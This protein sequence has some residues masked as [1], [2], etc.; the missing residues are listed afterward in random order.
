MKSIKFILPVVIISLIYLL[1]KLF[2]PEPTDWNPSYSKNDKIPYGSYILYEELNQLFPGKNIETT[3]LPFYNISKQRKIEDK[4][5]IIICYKF[6][7]D[8]LDAK[9]LLELLNSG[10]D[11][12]I[13]ATSVGNVFSDSLN[14]QTSFS[15]YFNSDSTEVNFVNPALARKTDYFFSNGKY[16]IYFSEIDT[17]NTIVLGINENDNPNFIKMKIGKGNLFLHSIPNIFTNYNLLKSNRDYIFKSLSYLK[18]RDVIWDEYYKE[19]NKY[20][21]TPIRY[22]LSQTSL[23]WGY[24]TFLFGIILFVIFR[25]KRDQRII[26]VIKPLTN[27]TLEFIQ[28]IGNVYLKQSNHK[29]I[30]KKRVV[31]FL[32]HIRNKYGIRANELNNDLIKQIAEK[33]NYDEK[34]LNRI[35]TIY[36]SIELSSSIKEETLIELNNLLENFYLKTGAYGK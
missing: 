28:T 29:N 33:T 8:E 15:I 27:T 19:V 25:G 21:S 5:I 2:T 12:F 35:R 22:I 4:N 17:N 31:Y 23:R 24:F 9:V 20:R 1:F 6:N 36:S 3:N 10:N 26:P 32:D 18:I 11:V 30:A 16:D 14:I 34:E 7:P 13:A